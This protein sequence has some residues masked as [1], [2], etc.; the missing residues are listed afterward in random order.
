MKFD[1][2]NNEELVFIYLL[3]SDM[4]KSYE[5]VLEDKGIYHEVESPMGKLK[6]F[7]EFTDEDMEKLNNSY[8]VKI[9]KS[10][11]SKL[12]PIVELIA[13]ADPDFIDTVEAQIFPTKDESQEEDL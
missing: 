12:T 2:L 5:K 3:T 8:K 7:Q 10:I 9:F 13:D 1:E 4:L 6:V 11:T